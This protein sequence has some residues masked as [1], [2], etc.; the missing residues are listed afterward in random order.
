VLILMIMPHYPAQTRR[1]PYKRHNFTRSP[2]F[3]QQL[4]EATIKLFML[5]WEYPQQL[6]Q[7]VY[8]IFQDRFSKGPRL[9][10][11]R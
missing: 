1:L 10:R 8:T 5:F 4:G 2:G 7:T 9:G 11:L 3:H 6:A